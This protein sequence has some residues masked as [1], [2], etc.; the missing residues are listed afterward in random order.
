MS[1]NPRIHPLTGRPM[2]EHEQPEAYVSL[3]SPSRE[4]GNPYA[5]SL[6][7]IS[8]GLMVLGLIIFVAGLGTEATFENPTGGAGAVMAGSG[9]MG[10]GWVL[11][12]AW[13]A[14]GSINWV[15]TRSRKLIDDE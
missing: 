7:F 4:S 5:Q 11:F 2:S 15:R 12:V 8:I 1:E 9:L 3:P 13:L 10:M 14:T 6:L